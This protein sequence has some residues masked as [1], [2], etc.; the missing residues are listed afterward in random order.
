MQ[1]KTYQ[2][3]AL[4]QLDLWLDA[5]KE[6]LQER[7][8]AK[9]FYGKRGKKIPDDMA[10]YPGSAWNSLK[11]QNVLPTVQNQDSP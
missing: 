6:A 2:H 4:D 7:E 1:L 10:D 5:L 3:N 8:E 11:A 9:E